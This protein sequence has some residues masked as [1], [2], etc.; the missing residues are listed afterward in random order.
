MSAM[1]ILFFFTSNG[2]QQLVSEALLV[3]Q[4]IFGAWAALTVFY[5]MI[6][7][8]REHNVLDLLLTSGVAKNT[9][10]LSKVLAAC[11]VALVLTVL[12]LLP[13]TA[14][15]AIGTGNLGDANSVLRYALPLWGHIMAYASL[16]LLISVL[17]R[18]SKA[19]LVWSMALGLVLMPRFYV[20]LLKSVQNLA[21]WPEEI[22][23]IFG[24]L[25]P[26]V[27]MSVLADPSGTASFY[28]ALLGLTLGILGALVIAHRAFTRQDELSYGE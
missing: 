4:M 14:I 3:P 6:S 24:Y 25:S 26:G 28:E 19:S 13:I 1:C 23:N 27:S 15:L 22:T 17:A 2:L 10:F 16:G 18:S 9:V 21:H 12:Y 20:M 8:D 5:D 7:T 11:V